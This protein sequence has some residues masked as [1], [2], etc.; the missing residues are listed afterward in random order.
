MSFAFRHTLPA[1]KT[2]SI[3]CSLAL[4]VFALAGHAH[5]AGPKSNKE[6]GD[7][8]VMQVETTSVSTLQ[9]RE[10]I[11]AQGSLVPWREAVVSPQVQ[12]LAIV[13]ILVD[14]GDRVERGQLLA[15]LDQRLP[16][17]E[18]A[19]ARAQWFEAKA[20]LDESELQMERA[21]QL[22]AK[23]FFS[24]SQLSQAQNQG[25][26]AR[27]R[28][29]AA[30]AAVELRE[31]QLTQTQLRASES[32]L[33]SA[34]TALLGAMPPIGA[35]LFK[36]HVQGK[37]EWRA[38]VTSQDLAR[39]TAGN[40][41]RVQLPSGDSL[42][43]KVRILG[44]LIDHATRNGQVLVSLAASPKQARVGQFLQGSIDVGQRAVLSIPQSALVVRDGFTLVFQI[45][46]QGRVRAHKVRAGAIVG[47]RVEILE[48]ISAG[49]FVVARG[50]AFLNDG[51]LVRTAKP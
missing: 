39:I 49:A 48:G 51:D 26:M 5:G 7:K 12:G 29:E 37:L 23:G 19:Q 33:I 32:G 1:A 31:L 3:L 17:A 36:I 47:D 35:E 27:A 24:E 4:I 34:K 13:E 40:T 30:Q 21:L 8:P 18:L 25:R 22:R 20:S 28:L 6:A 45:D 41:A 42:E 43:G 15:R 44:P 16:L 10:R 38:E 14:V 46:P 2:S 9:S 50:A 11:Q